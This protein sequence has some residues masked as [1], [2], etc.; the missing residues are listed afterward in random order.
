MQDAS[1]RRSFLKAV[2]AGTAAAFLASLAD[3]R[4]SF[5]EQAADDLGSLSGADPFARL[6]GS[7]TLDP[8][9]TYLNHAS[10]GTMPRAVQDAHRQYLRLCEMNPWLHMWGDVWQ[11]PR[12]EVRRQAAL[13]FGCTSDEITFS[14]NTTETFNLLAQGLP[15]GPSDEVLFSSLNHSGASVCWHHAA[16]TRG[17]SVRQFDFPASRVP[18]LTT[19]EVL[20]IYGRAIRPETR[21]LALPHVDNTLGLRLPL[22]RITALARERGV[23]FVVVDAAQT[24][25]MIP[26]DVAS[27]GIDAYATSAHKW[28][29]APKG[30]GVAYLH[31]D[32]HEILRPL[33]VT[34]GK[35]RWAGSARRYEDYGTR[36]LAEVLT[37]GDALAFQNELGADRV[38]AHH[39]RLWTHAR[40]RVDQSPALRWGSPRE[41]ELSAA[42]YSVGISGERASDVFP[43]L[44]NR[45]GFV[46]RPFE[47]H[48]LNALRVSPN[49]AN[50]TGD[51][52][53]LFSILEAGVRG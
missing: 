52:D 47:T 19:A 35:E 31:R 22:R 9:V 13:F 5:A 43:R 24:A 37:L 34:W 15:I 38:E 2:G 45:Y 36:N 51:L 3:V 17:F 1:S 53:R 29:Q 4:G 11:E 27:W 49:T 6:N 33:W 48:G 7:Y 50:T 10:I 46:V 25:G 8:G 30:L 20:E 21:V 42:L 32:L 12:E 16:E 41:W 40:E 18:E 39:R 23:R 44:F 28:L 26:L 14:H